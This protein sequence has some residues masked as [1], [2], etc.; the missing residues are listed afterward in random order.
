MSKLI[1]IE[2]NSVTPTVNI[3]G[4]FGIINRNKSGNKSVVT[5]LKKG[6]IFNKIYKGTVFITLA[7]GLIMSNN[8]RYNNLS[9][10]KNTDIYMVDDSRNLNFN[11][12]N[13]MT[14]IIQVNPSY[15]EVKTLEINK[16]QGVDNMLYNSRKVISVNGRVKAKKV[17]RLTEPI[18]DLEYCQV[19]E[20]AL[21]VKPRKTVI[22]K[23]KGKVNVVKRADSIII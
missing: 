17:Y 1:N 12:F 18:N 10:N 7:T 3:Q 8:S 15:N 14:R 19:E 4:K 13:N 9:I 5:E 11:K 20:E 22:V 23:N 6:F 2:E 21:Q 16:I